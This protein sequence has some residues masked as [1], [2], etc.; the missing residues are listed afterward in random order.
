MLAL[1]TTLPTSAL[2]LIQRVAERTTARAG[3]EGVEANDVIRATI[4]IAYVF[5]PLGNYFAALFVF[6]ATH[7]FQVTMSGLDTV[8]L[9]ALMLLSCSGS[10]S[11]TIEA[12]CFVS[13]WLGL[14]A[15]TV[16]LYVEAM[17]ITRYGL[18]ALSVSAYAF[19]TIAVPLVYFRCVKWRLQQMITA[20]VVGVVLLVG[21]AVGTR[22]LAS[23]SFPPPSN[24]EILD[25]TL[26]PPLV[27][28]VSAVV[29][30]EPASALPPIDAPAT[31]EGIRARGVIRVGYG[32]DIVPFTY[33]NARGELVGFDISYAYQLARALHVRLELAPIDW[34]TFE[35]DLIVRR[36]D[37]IMAG[38]YV[39][40]SRIEHLQ[41]TNSYFQSP[42]ALIARSRDAGRFLSYEAIAGAPTLTLGVL[43]YP[44]L[45]PMVARLFPNARIVPLAS[46]EELPAHH[47]I[48]AAVWSL[49]QARAWAS[50]HRGYTAVAP[51][52]MGAPLAFAYLLPPDTA[53]MSRFMTLWLELQSGNGFR[54]A[55]IDYWINGE[56][57]RPTS[58]R[59][60]LLDNVLMPML[61]TAR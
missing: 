36:F 40:D 47:E 54:T 2:P 48:D 21:V 12:I 45:L 19:A 8:L 34:T 29:R 13:E 14:P 41:V 7:R 9:P 31:M 20:L 38:A 49:D 33:T 58:P 44:A 51:A 27:A 46:Y 25:R 1:V 37:I 61:Q 55:Q 24:A 50:A 4:S 15:S 32:R 5:A 39:T 56:P 6:Y 53:A 3:H 59:W 17:T 18:V 26:D 22:M 16:P 11:T 42:L 30:N 57:R 23:R 43:N 60:N 35:A 10:P 52:N 28:G